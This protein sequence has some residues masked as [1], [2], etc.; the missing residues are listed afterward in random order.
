MNERNDESMTNGSSSLKR[1]ATVLG[2]ASVCMAVSGCVGPAPQSVQQSFSLI[3]LPDTQKYSFRFPDQFMAQTEWIKAQRDTLNIVCVV[4]EGDVTERNT[5]EE[6]KVA[7]QAMSVLDGIVPYCMNVGNHDLGPG[8]PKTAAQTREATGYNQYFGVDRFEKESWYGGHFGD[9]NENAFYFFN[10]GGM[11]FMVLCLEFG[12]RD[13]VLAW[14]NKIVAAHES[15]RTIVVTHCYTYSD[16]TRVGE[17]D[18]WS[19]HEYG[20]QGNDGEE[21]WDK[22][23]KHHENI[24]LVLSGHVLNDGLGRLTS[25]GTQG[26]D[27]H[28]I[29][30]N[31]QMQNKGGSGWLRIMRFLP[32]ENKIEV[33]TY[34]PTL[35]QYA[36]DEQNQFELEYGMDR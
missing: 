16:N 31:Y 24:F 14:A 33:R 15:Y 17:G 6:W 30:A 32:S 9:G 13:E 19:P 2:M 1:T 11:D 23:V 22:F 25:V 26:N 4:H 28:Q 18:L 7:D 35:N 20:S 36:E 8:G 12:P 10:A 21:M 3:V 5:E 29:L 34:S 27:V